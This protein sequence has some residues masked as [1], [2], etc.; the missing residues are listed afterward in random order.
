MQIET[1]EITESTQNME[2]AEAHKEIAESL[3]LEK[4]TALHSE[5]SVNTY[6]KMTDQE[7]FTYGTLFPVETDISVYDE[8][9][10]VRVLQVLAHFKET[11]PEYDT[12]VVLHNRSIPDPVLIATRYSFYSTGTN[13]YILA[14]WGDALESLDSLTKKA[15]EVFAEQLPDF[16]KLPYEKLNKIREAIK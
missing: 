12:F 4:Q 5:K 13:D 8:F 1:Y 3:G 14:R 11:V 10:P 15:K 2:E 6:R 7:V 9:I 16:S